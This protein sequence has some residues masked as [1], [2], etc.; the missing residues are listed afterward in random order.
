PPV[1]RLEVTAIVGYEHRERKLA[2][3]GG[4]QQ[5]EREARFSGARRAADQHR[6]G[7]DQHSGSVDRGHF[8]NAPAHI[9]GRRTMKRAPRTVGSPSAS[10]I[11]TRF[12]AHRRPPCAS[13]ICSEIDSPSPEFWPNPWCGRSV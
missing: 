11:S 12:S 4:A 9:A 10:P 8:G 3:L 6:A 2:N 1:L 7:A 5:R 13:T